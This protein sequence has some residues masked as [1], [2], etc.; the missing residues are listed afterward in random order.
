MNPWG[1]V[2]YGG[3]VDPAGNSRSASTAVN[4]IE[5]PDTFSTLK[6]RKEAITKPRMVWDQGTYTA[7]K[8]NCHKR[9]RKVESMVELFNK[10]SITSVQDEKIFMVKLG[11]ISAAAL[12]ALEYISE[13]LSELE[14]N[15]EQERIT[16]IKAIKKIVLDTVKEN[17]KEVKVEMERLLSE[18]APAVPPPPP[19]TTEGANDI[20]QVV[21]QALANLNLSGPG[22]SNNTSSIKSGSDLVARLTL[23]YSHVHE[24]ASDFQKLLASVKLASDMSDSEIIY[25]MRKSE[26]WT[27]KVE[28]LV[29]AN[30]KFQ[31]ESLGNEELAQMAEQLNEKVQIVKQV[32]ENKM[33]AIS[34]VDI[35][36]GLNSL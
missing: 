17:E 23:R 31:E 35:S 18:A 24:D 27:K 19:P 26:T 34:Q 2:V 11:E 30:R 10:D 9:K 16:E 28:E 6:P 22:A 7:Y 5:F 15:E 14:T 1:G 12:E 33:S 13:I 21:Q 20:Q 32:K 8:L 3:E 29:A 36:R 25:F 4:R